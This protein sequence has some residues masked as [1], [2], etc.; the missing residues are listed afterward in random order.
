MPWHLLLQK[1]IGRTAKKVKTLKYFYFTCF[2]TEILV[3]SSRLKLAKNEH[4][5]TLRN[6]PTRHKIMIKNGRE[7]FSCLKLKL[8]NKI[9]CFTCTDDQQRK[10]FLYK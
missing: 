4:I 8:K 7:I 3:L 10:P 2:C 9:C 5:P 1:T 6:L